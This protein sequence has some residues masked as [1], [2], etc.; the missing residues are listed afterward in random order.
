MLRRLLVLVL[1][2]ALPLWAGVDVNNSAELLN[3][4]TIP[5]NFPM[6]IGGWI[7][8]YAVASDGDGLI[9]SGDF[10]GGVGSGWMLHATDTYN[11]CSGQIAFI[12]GGSTG[13][14][15]TDAIICSGQSLVLNKWTFVAAVVTSTTV[16]FVT[17]T[18]SGTLTGT[19]QSDNNAFTTENSPGTGV[20]SSVHISTPVFLAHGT[21]ANV[22]VYGTVALSDAELRSVA[23]FGPRG[24]SGPVTRFWPLYSIASTTA[25]K[26]FGE[27]SGN[28]NEATTS[29]TTNLK[30]LTGT[31]LQANH[32][33]CADPWDY[34]H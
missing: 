29:T 4:N 33:P 23:R 2:L 26:S 18:A 32:C 21:L 31:A 13:G 10:G 9:N 3:G 27:Y 22:F 7:N 17:I 14:G 1:L 24:I 11:G 30:L 5:G 8:L 34:H 16:R 19:T 20:G 12:K 25:P 15:A 28:N 6:T